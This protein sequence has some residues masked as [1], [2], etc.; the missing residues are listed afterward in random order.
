[1]NAIA[2]ANEPPPPTAPAGMFA[3]LPGPIRAPEIQLSEDQLYVLAKVKQGESVFFTGSAGTGKSVLLR[4]IIKYCGG[5]PSMRLGVTASTG[6]ASVNIG[7]CTLH[8]WAGIG[9]GKEDKDGLVGKILGMSARAYKEDVRK[10]KE[11]WK[12]KAAGGQLTGE[13]LAFLNTDPSDTVKN[14][15]LDRWRQVKTLIIDESAW[16]VRSSLACVPSGWLRLVQFR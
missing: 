15:S 9:L 2:D 10:R 7:G 1:M 16:V 13:E 6:I 4:E 5:K 11:L 12:K 14:R 3:S 8:S